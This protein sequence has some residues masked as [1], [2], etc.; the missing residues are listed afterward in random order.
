MDGA[1]VVGGDGDELTRLDMGELQPIVVCLRMDGLGE[2][3]GDN[4]EILLVSGGGDAD[5]GLGDATSVTR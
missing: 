2:A 1:T 5:D 3:T 4:S